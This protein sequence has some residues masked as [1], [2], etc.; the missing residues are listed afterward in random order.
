MK[1][2]KKVIGNLEKCYAL[3]TFYYD[4]EDHLVATAEKKNPRYSFDVA[5]HLSDTH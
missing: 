1:A 3:G 5:G 4:G 2:T